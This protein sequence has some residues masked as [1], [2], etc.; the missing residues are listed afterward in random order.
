MPSLCLSVIVCLPASSFFVNVYLFVYSLLI[1]FGNE[2]SSSSPSKMN[3][4]LASFLSA[5]EGP[6]LHLP[7]INESSYSP[8]SG[9]VKFSVIPSP[10]FSNPPR[11]GG[12]VVR[13]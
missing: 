10:S 9:T 12:T 13:R 4:A 5:G 7:Y 3:T 8:F 6:S 2:I 1:V 11:Y